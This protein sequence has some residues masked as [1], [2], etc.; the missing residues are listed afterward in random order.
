MTE[1]SESLH[2][3]VRAR[4]VA[5]V[6]WV[7]LLNLLTLPLSFATN[8]LLARMGP[9]AIGYYGAI[10]LF[11]GGFQTFFV[12]GGNAVF[13]RLV[14]GLR[15]GDRISFLLTY[16]GLVLGLFLAVVAGLLALAPESAQALLARFGSPSTAVAVAL[17]AVVVV[18]AFTSHFLYAVLD[19][20]GGIVTLKSVVI[21]FFAAGLG[22]WIVASERMAREPAPVLWGLTL[23]VY[24]AGAALGVGFLLRTAEFREREAL[25]LVMPPKFVSV[26]AYTHLQTLV[27]FI[28]SGLASSIVLYRLDVDALGHL[29]AAM[30]YPLLFVLLPAAMASV[31]APGLS[32]LEASGRGAESLRQ[33]T[34]VLRGALVVVPPAVF[35]LI[36]FAGDA[37]AL[38]G[39][40]Y[41]RDADVLAIV[42]LSAL[43][44]PL[45]HLGSGLLIARGA[46]R[47]YL[48]ASVVYVAVA[49]AL[50]VAL[51]PHLGLV[52]AALAT[53]GGEMVQY[54]CLD[55]ALRRRFGLRLGTRVYAAWAFGLAVCAAA[56]LLHP[57]RAL[58]G[59]LLL[60][61]LALYAWV[62]RITAEEVGGLFRRLL[63]RSGRGA[64]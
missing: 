45:V 27:G 37:M 31:V 39:P 63:S 2:A 21:G 22:T 59:V 3:D 15:R 64:P 58:S 12:L 54:G 61:A 43:A 24:A 30:R 26:V 11:I 29:H 7:L 5:G 53:T 19:A 13:T 48:V 49:A 4:T 60:A 44:A 16:G 47:T 51:V 1:G 42:G 41:R 57:G 14:P 18:W 40:D 35:A 55:A 50:A 6:R 34:A 46:F 62:G 28:Y 8:L 38:F 17:G 25:R 52:G 33:L 32:T 10:Q 20:R 36:L 9:S 56:V 23:A